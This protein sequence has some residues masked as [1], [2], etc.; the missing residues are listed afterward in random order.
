MN[1]LPTDYK[2]PVLAASMAGAR[3][4]KLVPLENGYYNIIDVTEYLQEG[5]KIGAEAFNAQN[6]AINGVSGS[7]VDHLE[8]TSSELGLSANQG[9]VL[10]EKIESRTETSRGILTAGDTSITIYD[11]RIVEGCAIQPF[12]SIDGVNPTSKI[13]EVGSITYTFDAQESDMEVGVMV[14]V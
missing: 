5:S 12:T 13:V 10:N 2:D 3:Q 1:N 9:R 14:Y 7:F 8:S 6:K 4:Y 11:E